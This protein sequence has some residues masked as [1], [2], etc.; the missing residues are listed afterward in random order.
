MFDFIIYDIVNDAKYLEWKDK[1]KRLNKEY[2]KE[3][4][5]GYPDS[6]HGR[7]Y[8]IELIRCSH[9]DEPLFNWRYFNQ[10]MINIY[11][12]HIITKCQEKRN[13][14]WKKVVKLSKN[15]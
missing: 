6:S 7:F 14:H 2:N 12:Y 10:I 1:I 4:Y 9:C 5:W 11:I 8:R 15:Y 3:I 13:D